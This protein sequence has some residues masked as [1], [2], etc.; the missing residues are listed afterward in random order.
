MAGHLKHPDDYT[1]LAIVTDGLWMSAFVGAILLVFKSDLVFRYA[2]I[3]ALGVGSLFFAG[4][5]ELVLLPIHVALCVFA[6][7]ALKGWLS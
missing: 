6:V 3:F 1:P 4:L 7:A 5:G 2:F